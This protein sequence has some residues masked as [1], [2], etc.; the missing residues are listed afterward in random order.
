MYLPLLISNTG[1]SPPGGQK[2]AITSVR[3]VW[4]R[5]AHLFDGTDGGDVVGLSAPLVVTVVLSTF[6]HVPQVLAAPEVLLLV[7]DPSGK[8]RQSEVDLPIFSSI[9]V[10]LLIQL[11]TRPLPN[12]HHK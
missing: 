11:V 12:L 1:I 6:R 4:L 10:G 8:R 3:V 2:I 9:L 5:R 7:T